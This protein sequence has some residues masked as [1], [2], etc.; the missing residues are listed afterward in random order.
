MQQ[1][2]CK[3]CLTI[4]ITAL[5]CVLPLA[6]SASSI[7]TVTLKDGTVYPDVTYHVNNNHKTIELMVDEDKRAVS[8]TDILSIINDKGEDITGNVIGGYYKPENEETWISESSVVYKAASKKLYSVAF[9]VGGHFCFPLGEYYE[10]VV[11]T[12]GFDAN[13]IIAVTGKLGLRATVSR[14]GL[15]PEDNMGFIWLDAYGP[16]YSLTDFDISTWRYMLSVQYGNRFD[17]ETPGKTGW[18]LFSGIGAI[19]HRISAKE[20]IYGETPDLDVTTRVSNTE[21]KFASTFGVGIVQL[22]SPTIGF[23][24]GADFDV[25]YLGRR[26]DFDLL[27]G[28]IDYAYQFDLKLGLTLL[29]PNE[30]P[31]S[32]R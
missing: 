7:G 26:E 3:F 14:A 16:V 25:L 27:G 32:G 15:K 9:Q 23:Y 24:V 19:S 11:S 2:I 22:F 6:A 28:G 20:T 13:L 8:F 18:Y 1:I 5:I 10:G 4:L 12:V 30:N 21:T 31:D 29:V 17:R